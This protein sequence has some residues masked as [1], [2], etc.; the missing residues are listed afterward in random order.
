MKKVKLSELNDAV[1]QDADELIRTSEEIFKNKLLSAA[2]VI[3]ERSK[4]SPLVLMSGPSSS[5]KTTTAKTLAGILK[6]HGLKT[7]VLSM[8]DYFKSM[9][10]YEPPKDEYGQD[11][12][13]SPACLDLSLLHEQL[14]KMWRGEEV[15]LPK[16]D[17][18]SQCRM[19]EGEPL[20]IGRDEIVIMEGIHALNDDVVSD[21]EDHA[22]KIYISVRTRVEDEQGR[23]LP[24]DLVR[25][26]RRATRD[27]LFRGTPFEQ[28]LAMWRRVRRGELLYILPYKNEADISIDSFFRYE[29]NILTH[30]CHDHYMAAPFE[31]LDLAGVLPLMPFIGRFTKLE[32]EVVPKDSLL[33]EFI[34]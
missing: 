1:L 30:I 2:S 11:D 13:E 27:E 26:L 25:F 6:N 10:D 5:G 22:T 21:L 12:L 8:D 29:L 4:R 7:H 23:I 18:R 28:T 32:R 17:F 14:G 16:F 31:K 15:L 34:G 33:R 9:K 24:P 19:S 3:K 20:K